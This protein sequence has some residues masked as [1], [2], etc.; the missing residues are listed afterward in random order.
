MLD[1]TKIRWAAQ[2]ADVNYGREELLEVF[3]TLADAKASL[4]ARY[5]T[6]YHHEV[7][8]AYLDSTT[9][10]MLMPTVTPE[11]TLT[12]WKIDP[13]V[14]FADL[15]EAWPNG[16][17]VDDIPADHIVTLA[18]LRRATLRRP[19]EHER[20][21]SERKHREVRPLSIVARLKESQ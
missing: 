13:P 14:R 9:A 7:D 16:I 6:G 21:E 10:R 8:L 17:P 19:A 5:D 15:A 12:L 1:D 11:A 4:E 3:S 2:F 20:I 18:H